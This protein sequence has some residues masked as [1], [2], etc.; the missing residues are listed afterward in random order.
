MFGTTIVKTDVALIPKGA[1]ENNEEG[2]YL[3]GWYATVQDQY[4]ELYLEVELE[5]HHNNIP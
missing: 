5:L 4:G 3:D 2:F 1:T